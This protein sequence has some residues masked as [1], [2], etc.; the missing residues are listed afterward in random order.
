MRKLLFSGYEKL[1]YQ[2]AARL[3]NCAMHCRQPVI[4]FCARDFSSC[5][6]RSEP[7]R[8]QPRRGRLNAL[9]ARRA[10]QRVLA[11]VREIIAR[12]R[13]FDGRR[14]SRCF[15]YRYSGAAQRNCSYGHGSRGGVVPREL[16]QLPFVVS[17]KTKSLRRSFTCKDALPKGFNVP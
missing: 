5:N 1:S 14:K 8:D 12:T 6:E 16:P 9:F 15:L 17:G 10:T 3:S 7:A 13:K 4:G 11:A 2:S